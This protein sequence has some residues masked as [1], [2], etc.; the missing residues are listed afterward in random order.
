MMNTGHPAPNEVCSAK[1]TISSSYGD[2]LDI[3]PYSTSG[4]MSSSGVNDA[5]VLLFINWGTF[6]LLAR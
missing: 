5:S 2:Y 4:R 6:P 3:L 1:A